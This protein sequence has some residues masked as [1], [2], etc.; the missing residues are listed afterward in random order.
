MDGKLSD[1]SAKIF[2][3]DLKTRKYRKLVYNYHEQVAKVDKT[4]LA[5]AMGNSVTTSDASYR[6]RDG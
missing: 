6:D 4:T 1:M 2:G 5:K 3:H